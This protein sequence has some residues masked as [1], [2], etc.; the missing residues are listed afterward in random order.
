MFRISLLNEVYEEYCKLA[1]KVMKFFVPL[2][3][4]F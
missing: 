2:Q 4:L 3:R 1:K